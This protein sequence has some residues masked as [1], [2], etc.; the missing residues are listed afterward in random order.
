[1]N[2]FIGEVKTLCDEDHTGL[3]E[4]WA[5]ALEFFPTA[6]S[7]QRRDLIVSALTA[8]LEKKQ[9][10]AGV[11]ASDGIHFVAAQ[12]SPSE[13]SSRVAETLSAP[14]PPRLGEGL[15]FSSPTAVKTHRRAT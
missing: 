13:I 3:W 9:I 6:T 14:I 15:W 5:L 10:V 1:M 12:G 7:R 4:L 11:P 2:D 8:L